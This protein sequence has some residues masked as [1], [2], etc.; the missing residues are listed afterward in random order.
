MNAQT[1]PSEYM[2]IF[3]GT[4]WH[5]GL[6]PEETQK[7]SSQ[8]MTWFNRLTEQGKALA[9]NPLEN[10][11]KI[12]S[13]K[14]GRVVADGPFAES[15]EAIGGYFLLQVKN[16]EEAVAIAQECPG[17]AYGAVVEVRPVAE[18]CPLAEEA[19]AEVEFAQRG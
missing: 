17:L 13:G 15:K 11:G 7:V 14:N 8:W 2:L 9:G 12:I 16:L 1:K 3:R 6:S 4:D 10:Q 19:R 5:K 18:E